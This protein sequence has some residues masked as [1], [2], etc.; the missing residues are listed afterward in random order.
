MGTWGL[1]EDNRVGDRAKDPKFN[2]K[3]VEL[4]SE[5][6]KCDFRLPGED[7]SRQLGSESG[8]TLHV[9][10]RPM[11]KKKKQKRKKGNI[12]ENPGTGKRE[13]RDYR[14][15]SRSRSGFGSR[16]EADDCFFVR[17]RQDES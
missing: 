15:R 17:G 3:F 1:G 4:K 8:D 16:S 11:T 5:L 2:R 7:Q 14:S 13:S 10:S 9:E 6:K 12:R